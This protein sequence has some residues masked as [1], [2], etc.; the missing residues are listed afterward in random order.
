MTCLIRRQKCH[1][2][3]MWASH[4]GSHPEIMNTCPHRR[5]HGHFG[6]DLPMTHPLY[7]GDHPAPRSAHPASSRS[8][9]TR[10]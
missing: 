7:R 4:L 9:E 2:L 3:Q 10:S 1:S 8:L 6:R 5:K